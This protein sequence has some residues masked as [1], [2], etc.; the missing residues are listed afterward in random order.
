MNCSIQLAISSPGER[1]GQLELQATGSQ[2][3]LD[4]KRPSRPLSP[5][6]NQIQLNHALFC[7]S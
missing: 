1:I 2:N 4:W 5:T 7:V 3:H 6:V